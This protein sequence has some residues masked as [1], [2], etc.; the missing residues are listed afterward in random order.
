MQTERARNQ[1]AYQALKGE[2]EKKYRGR[3][4]AIA[5]GKIVADGFSFEEVIKKA[6]EVAPEVSQRI[7]LKVGEEYPQTVTVGGPIVKS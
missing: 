3:F 2:L 1:Q 4:V 7:V 5:R 6:E